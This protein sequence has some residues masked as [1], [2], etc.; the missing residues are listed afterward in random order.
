MK[1]SI[2]KQ[3]NEN[4]YSVNIKFGEYGS[5]TITAEEEKE[6]LQD[7][8]P[9]FYLRDVNFKGMY[10]YDKENKIV[11]EYMKPEEEVPAEVKTEEELG[12]GEPDIS[13]TD[14]EG[15][16]VAIDG[17]EYQEV[18]T[19]VNDKLVDINDELELKCVIKSTQILDNEVGNSL[20]NKGLV[21]QAKIQL[22]TDKIIEKITKI[23]DELKQRKT[24]FEKIDEVI[25]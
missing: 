12:I 16:I 20:D 11:K 14:G 9:C 3:I 1:L 19:N 21:A 5:T 6:L 17:L 25:I 4:V 22:F 2:D 13:V 15:E 8:A 23:M 18:I 10:V 7:F 24:N